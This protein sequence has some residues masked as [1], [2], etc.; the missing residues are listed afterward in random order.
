MIFLLFPILLFA[1]VV[2]EIQ[3]ER[4]Y[5]TYYI[6]RSD[7]T[8][9]KVVEFHWHSPSGL[10]DRVKI[11]QVPPF[12]GSV[13]DYRFLPGREKGK[14]IVEVKELD[15]GKTSTTSFE[16]NTTSEEFFED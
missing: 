10:D 11:F 8:E 1:D 7:N 5:C 3:E 2:C 6:N 16:L 13:Y 9:G 12:Y 15:T 14:W 4:I